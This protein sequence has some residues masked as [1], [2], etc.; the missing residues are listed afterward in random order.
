MQ[1]SVI[2]K[3]AI[4]L[5]YPEQIVLALMADPGGKTN[6]I[7]LGWSMVC[8]HEPPMLAIAVGNTRY[9]Y[10]L[11]SQSDEFVLA[12]PGRNMAKEALFCGTHSGRQVDKIAET[13]LELMPGIKGDVPLLKQAVANFEMR[14]TSRLLTGD[15]TIFAGTVLASYRHV[16]P[17]ERLYTLGPGYALGYPEMKQQQSG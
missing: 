12:F 7:T 15:H 5:K 16:D 1:E 9:S 11:L 3:K 13:G 17:P 2:Y 6:I 4:A 14:I 10:E 8:S